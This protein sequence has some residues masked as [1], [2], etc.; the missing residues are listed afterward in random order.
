MDFIS[1]IDGALLVLVPVLYFIG[2]AIKKS[3]KCDG[4]IPLILGGSGVLLAVLWVLATHSIANYQDALMAAFTAIV[5]GA[6]CAAGAVYAN[7]IKKQ[8]GKDE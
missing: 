5:Q 7:Q 1:Y 6:L 3:G 2:W 8:S 4:R